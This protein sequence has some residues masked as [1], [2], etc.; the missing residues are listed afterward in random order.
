[1]FVAH[2]PAGYLA[3]TALL[4]RAAMPPSPARR[5]LL[6][7][8]LAASVLPDLDLLW[9]YFVDNRQHVHHEFLPHLPLAWA[10]LAVAAVVL[11]LRR[12]GRTAWLALAVLAANVFLHLALDTV[13]EGVEWLWPFSSAEFV[14]SHVKPGH[15]PWW[16]NFVLH[17]TFALEIALLTAALVVWRGRRPSGARVPATE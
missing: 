14:L 6:A 1:M 17:W 5:R 16:L 11:R 15:D 9:F 4:D 7:I 10:V 8:G 13:A 2:L 12:A 3:T